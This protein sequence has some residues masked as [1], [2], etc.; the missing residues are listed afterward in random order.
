MV[1]KAKKSLSEAF[2]SQSFWIVCVVLVSPLLCVWWACTCSIHLAQDRWADP[3]PRP[4]L[5]GTGHSQNVRRW[6]HRQN[7]KAAIKEER[8]KPLAF[9]RVRRTL[10]IPS[11]STS[12]SLM[13]RRKATSDQLQSVLFGRFPL[14]IREMIYHYYLGDSE[15]QYIY[16]RDDNR[17]GHVPCKRKDHP[18]SPL[19]L[20]WNYDQT[21]SDAWIVRGN[22]HRDNRDRED[23][24]SLLVTCRRAYA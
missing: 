13:K 9:M 11:V 5:C 7:V 12:A 1:S 2:D 3:K 15:Y 4:G 17:L 19:G 23:M 22:D 14:E 20:A 6:R 21:A 10:T 8:P 16:R 24:L 18:T